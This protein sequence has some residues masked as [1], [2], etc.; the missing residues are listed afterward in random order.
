MTFS[1][2]SSL[3]SERLAPGDG[4]CD[5]IGNGP[6]VAGDDREVRRLDRHVGS[7]ANGDAEVGPCERR[8]VVDAVTDHGDDVSLRL[9]ALDLCVLVVGHDLGEHPVDADGRTHGPGRAFVVA[10]EQCH[11]EAEVP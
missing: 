6:Q 1:W 7:G 2:A 4:W 3:G 5:R 11:L 9:E 8:G 10:C